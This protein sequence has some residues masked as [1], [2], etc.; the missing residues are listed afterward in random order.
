LILHPTPT[1]TLPY[2]AAFGSIVSAS[3]IFW[4]LV[5]GVTEQRWKEQA[6]AL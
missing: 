4:L 1:Q 2:T 5:F 3:H 6:G